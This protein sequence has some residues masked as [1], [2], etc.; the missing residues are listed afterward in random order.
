MDVK[1]VGKNKYK[2]RNTI[3]V[4]YFLAGICLGVIAS[5]VLILV[6]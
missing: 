6:I 3:D 1:R 4:D 2:K 5:L